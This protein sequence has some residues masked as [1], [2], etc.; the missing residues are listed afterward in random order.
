MRL[1]QRPLTEADLEQ[2]WEIE[3]AAFHADPAHR[4]WWMRWERAAGPGRIE[5]LFI[6][7]RLVATA[8]VFALAQWFGGRAV[9]MG[10]LRAVAARPEHHGRGHAT[11]VVRAALDAMRARGE[12]VSALYPQVVRPY[13]NL[14]WAIAGTLVMRSVP[15]QALAAPFAAAETAVRRATRDDRDVVRAI[16][17]RVARTTNGFLRRPA[18]RWD[19]IFERFADDALYLAGEDGYLL[20][21]HAD[22]APASH[23]GFR[24]YALDLVAATPDALRA[25]WRLLGGMRSVVPSVAFRGGPTDPLAGLLDGNAVTVVR[26]RPWMLRLVDAAAAIAAR[27]YDADVRAAVPLE[28]VDETCP[29]NGGRFTLVVEAGV[30]RLEPGGSGAVRLGVG[31]LAALYTGW[32]TT[33]VL[34]RTGLVDGGSASERGALD[35]VFAGPTPWMLDEF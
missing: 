18:G 29:W 10:G 8:G 17:D 27:G 6:D 30:G 24:I 15:T 26:E 19:W 20:Y 4:D 33:A 14:G 16:Y 7:G 25:L 31:A 11:R 1:D 23:E 2:M 13:R 9:P 12:V 22:P 5:G 32:A 21:R 35:R 28:V 34:A 3:L